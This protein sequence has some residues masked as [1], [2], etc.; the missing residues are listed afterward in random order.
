VQII[1]NSI[2]LSCS[3]MF[4]WPCISIY[5]CNKNQLNALFILSLFHQTTS[6]CF[7]HICGP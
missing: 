4:C 6:T 1:Y 7:G 2:T 5:L 3:F